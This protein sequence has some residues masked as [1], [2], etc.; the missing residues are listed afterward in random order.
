MRLVKTG[1]ESLTLFN[2]VFGE[3]YHSTSMGAYSEALHKHVLPPLLLRPELLK[4]PRI[5]ILDI[6][7]GL[8][9]NT[10]ATLH[11]YR[12]RGYAG[13]IEIL[14]PEMDCA[15]LDSLR[16][17]PYCE[18][19]SEYTKIISKLLNN[20]SATLKGARVELFRGDAREYVRC[21][22]GGIDVIYQDAFSPAKN[23]ILW[24][25]EYF[26]ELF[27][28]A[29]KRAIVTTYTQAS[30][31]R[32]GAYL[33]GF[34]VYEYDNGIDRGGSIFSRLDLPLKRIDMKI[35]ASMNSELKAI[36]DSECVIK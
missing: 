14:S 6:C 17:F 7:F 33:A 10:F 19:L 8:G 1:D 25:V 9:Y 29:D 4:Q 5:R 22:L 3:H 36:L 21:V 24:S 18:P 11:E 31:V 32:Y 27:R 23:P 26:K 16:S 15:L 28:I 34:N 20:G 30:K 13:E 2:E 35:K 12:A